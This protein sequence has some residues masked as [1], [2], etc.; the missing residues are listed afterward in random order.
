MMYVNARVIANTLW[1]RLNG[2]HDPISH[3]IEIQ[4]QEG[5]IDPED[6]DFRSRW[7]LH[8]RNGDLAGA[9]SRLL[10]E[11]VVIPL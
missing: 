7:E 10:I 6:F 9:G 3:G 11:F 1:A 2:G 4:K 8:K 5:L